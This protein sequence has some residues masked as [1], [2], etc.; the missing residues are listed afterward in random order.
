MDRGPGLGPADHTV[1]D[2]AQLCEPGDLVVVNDTRVLPARLRLRRGGTGGAVEALLLEPVDER[3]WEALVRPSRRLRPGDLLVREGLVVEAVER[4]GEGR[5]HLRFLPGVDV[6]G[7][8]DRVGEV[9]LPPYLTGPLAD[10]ERYQTVFARRAASAAAPTAGLHLTPA[11]L[12]DLARRGVVVAR[13]ELVVGLATFR[14]ITSERVEDHVMHEEAYRI[15]PET[16]EAL[17]QRGQGRRVL[18]VG[19]TV[20]RALES[21]G[22]TGATEGR[23]DLFIRGDGYPFRVVDRV[24]TNFHVPRS[25][26]IVLVDAFMG[27]R[28]RDLYGAALDRGYRF[29]SFGDAM[30]IDR[31]TDRAADGVAP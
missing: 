13:L 21:W 12:D 16:L 23:T 6:T 7:V 19:T 28:W 26:L 8:L 3:T 25:S 14:P 9:P 11:V 20:V 5:W 1:A 18:A 4:V 24:L 30:L 31:A 27:P 15:P 17:H 22:A 2:L 29:L 10:P